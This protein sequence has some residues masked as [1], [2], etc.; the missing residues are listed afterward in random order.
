MNIPNMSLYRIPTLALSY[1]TIRYLR[2]GRVFGIHV[3]NLWHPRKIPVE[4]V[5]YGNRFTDSN[6]E[7]RIAEWHIANKVNFKLQTL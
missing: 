7:V 2:V 5:D 3:E 1:V 6:C 4:V